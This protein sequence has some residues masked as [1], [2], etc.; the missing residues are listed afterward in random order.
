LRKPAHELTPVDRIIATML[1]GRFLAPL[2]ARV[3][4]V[5]AAGKA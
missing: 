4:E 3:A 2:Q 5:R 1:L